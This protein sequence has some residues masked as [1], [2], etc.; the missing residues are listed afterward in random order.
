MSS[1]GAAPFRFD[2]KT[3]LVTGAGRGIGA[4]AALRLAEA[5]AQVMLANRS[6]EA[7]EA[8]AAELRQRGLQALAIPF[9]ADE[10]GCAEAVRAT[11]A[12]FGR[13]DVL[14]HN[15]GGCA[16]SPI[17]A[18]TSEVLEQTLQLNLKSCFW[19]TQAALPALRA[20]GG[21]IVITS[22]VTGPRVAMIDAAH[23]AA[24][25]AGV[26]GFIKSA[27][28]ELARDRITV[29][30]VEP[31]F[32]AKPRGRLSQPAVKERLVRYIPLAQAGE[33]DDVAFAMLYLASEQ[34]RWVTGQTLVVDGGM[35]LP[36][37]GQV[38]EELWQDDR[39]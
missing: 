10:A 26:N 16:W 31:G 5:G 29:N 19:L 4:A 24:A 32:V 8:V 11:L 20:R 12:A 15:A 28:L 25:K 17:E 30:G 6:L 14:I 2:G 38:M 3:A 23:Y 9:A 21:R 36:E 39:A 18:L 37:S 7:A 1:S 33:P 22:S 34:A 35:T 27:A 13:L